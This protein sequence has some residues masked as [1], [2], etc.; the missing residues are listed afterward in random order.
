MH[1]LRKCEVELKNSSKTLELKLFWL[2][3]EEKQD[4]D[5]YNGNENSKTRQSQQYHD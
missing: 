3:S 1:V 2:T 5:H 4:D